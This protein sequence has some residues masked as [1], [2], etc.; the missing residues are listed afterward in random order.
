M[1]TK[2]KVLNPACAESSSLPEGA[3][4]IRLFPVFTIKN[5]ETIS[6]QV[7]SVRLV[8][9]G[10][11]ILKKGTGRASKVTG[12]QDVIETSSPESVRCVLGVGKLRQLK[13]KQEDADGAYLQTP[14]NV[15][16]R[17]QGLFARLPRE[18]WPEGSAAFNMK[19]PVF[20]VDGNLYGMPAA[21]F[22]LYISADIT[23]TKLA[24]HANTDIDTSIYDFVKP[25]FREIFQE[26][27]VSWQSRCNPWS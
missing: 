25:D 3:D 6:M 9:G 10:N 2:F 4:I 7:P 18:F 1:F 8:G 15:Q 14:R 19:D 27:P 26:G 23:S 12:R 16:R 5:F 11:N 22:D 13:C 21:D 20:P 24:S 17:P